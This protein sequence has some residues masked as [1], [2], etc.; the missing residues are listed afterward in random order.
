MFFSEHVLHAI[1]TYAR[2]DL[3]IKMLFCALLSSTYI[4]TVRKLINMECSKYIYTARTE[5]NQLFVECR[6]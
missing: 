4:N 6:S 2:H 5:R 3:E 1:H